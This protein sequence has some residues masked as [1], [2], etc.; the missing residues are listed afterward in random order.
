MIRL[1]VICGFFAAIAF[2]C[3]AAGSLQRSSEALGLE[4]LPI[5]YELPDDIADLRGPMSIVAGECVVWRY[6]FQWTG[7][8]KNGRRVSIQPG[9][10]MTL[11][12]SADSGYRVAI[13]GQNF[14]V[15]Q[16][17]N[18][19]GTSSLFTLAR[20]SIQD[21]TM[22]IVENRL[23]RPFKVL[24]GLESGAASFFYGKKIDRATSSLDLKQSETTGS[25]GGIPFSAETSTLV[26]RTTTRSYFPYMFVVDFS[27]DG[28]VITVEDVR[29]GADGNRAATYRAARAATAKR[30]A[31]PEAH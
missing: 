11:L 19:S 9:L 7:T 29:H 21:A 27:P 2:D 15:A 6:P 14:T 25:V 17:P 18:T 5:S 10:R 3:A 13:D 31:Q 26:P 24:P 20:I 12:G 16:P 8:G 1:C 30:A 28:R 4:G 23:G 22:V